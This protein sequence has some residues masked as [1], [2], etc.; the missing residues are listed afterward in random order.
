LLPK[1]VELMGIEPVDLVMPLKGLPGAPRAGRGAST[2]SQVKWTH[3]FHAHSLLARILL[4]PIAA[5]L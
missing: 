4:S 2:S 5:L 3:T 1:L